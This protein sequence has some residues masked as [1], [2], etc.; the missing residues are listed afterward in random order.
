VGK[1]AGLRKFFSLPKIFMLLKDVIVGNR[2][3][4]ALAERFMF[5]GWEQH[6]SFS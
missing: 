6:A 5:H 4:M 1:F 2:E 3:G